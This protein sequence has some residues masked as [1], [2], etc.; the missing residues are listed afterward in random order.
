MRYLYVCNATKDRIEKI[1]LDNFEEVESIY[2][3][4]SEGEKLSPRGVCLYED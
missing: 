3:K 4:D 2:I 1:E